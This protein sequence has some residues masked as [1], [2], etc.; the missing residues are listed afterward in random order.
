MVRFTEVI[1]KSIT[2]IPFT[3]ILT[4]VLFYSQILL[5]INIFYKRLISFQIFVNKKLFTERVDVIDSFN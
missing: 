5:V 1:Y 2:H 4:S 3:I